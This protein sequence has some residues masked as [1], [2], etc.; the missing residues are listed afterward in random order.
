MPAYLAEET[1]SHH[2]LE[3]P[4]LNF[5]LALTDNATAEYTFLTDF[6][7]PH[8]FQYVARKFSD[9]FEPTFD[10]GR[11]LTKY[12][13]DGNPDC[14]GVLLCVR[15]NQS[16]AFELQR[17]K[18]PCLDSYTNATNMLLWPRF[19][20]IMDLHGDSLRRATAALSGR[21]TAALALMGTDASKQ[22]TAPHFL[23]Q[24]FGQFLHAILVL[25][26]QAGDDEPVSNSLGR[27]RSDYDAF[28]V[29]CSRAIS[30]NRKRQ[31]FLFNNYSLILTII[32]VSPMSAACSSSTCWLTL[33]A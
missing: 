33:G 26:G 18:V 25:S 6:L 12:L 3:V 30:D 5:N 13:I 27:L 2:Y 24:R 10:L 11:K 17:R 4:F 29:K 21:S 20:I 19:Q 1:S 23:T 15:L 7:A 31:R 14:L 28:L 16:F 32:G 9:I 8:S 22:S